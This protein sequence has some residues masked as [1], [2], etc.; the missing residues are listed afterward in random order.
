[1]MLILISLFSV[2]VT[3]GVTGENFQNWHKALV[4]NVREQAWTATAAKLP[5]G[6]LRG[7]T[8]RPVSFTLVSVTG[9]ERTTA[10]PTCRRLTGRTA[11]A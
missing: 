7:R 9:A 3:Q 8:I 11:M 6:P 5:L 1:M 4:P 2:P 10:S